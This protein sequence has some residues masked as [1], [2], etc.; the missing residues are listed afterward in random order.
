MKKLL[1]FAFIA[2]LS[3]GMISVV[4]CGGDDSG[5]GTTDTTGGDDGGADDGGDDTGGDD[6]GDDGGS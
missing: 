3:F 1:T 2:M 4:G 5:T 6:G